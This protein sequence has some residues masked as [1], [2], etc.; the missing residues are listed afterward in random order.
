MM[1]LI[2]ILCLFLVC[3]L[4]YAESAMQP[5]TVEYDYCNDKGTVC[6]KN[7]IEYNVENGQ[8]TASVGGVIE[9]NT[10]QLLNLDHFYRNKCSGEL[11]FDQNQI[12]SKNDISKL[13]DCLINNL[14]PAIKNRNNEN[15]QYLKETKEIFK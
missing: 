6:G 3:N 7:K 2:K 10:D 5:P 12:I 8:K 14:E 13:G 15:N 11:G 9:S 1:K 4:G